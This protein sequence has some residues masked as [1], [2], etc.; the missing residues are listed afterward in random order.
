MVL[1]VGQH[2]AGALAAEQTN[3]CQPVMSHRR[4]SPFPGHCDERQ[5]RTITAFIHVYSTRITTV[6]DC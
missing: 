6:V 2:K 5:V 4:F 1:M 3:T